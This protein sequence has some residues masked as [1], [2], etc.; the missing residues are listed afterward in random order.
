MTKPPKEVV[1][2]HVCIQAK[3]EKMCSIFTDLPP[4]IQ[5]ADLIFVLRFFV[6]LGI[7]DFFDPTTYG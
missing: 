1:I 3:N 5:D 7:E 4:I 6:G 2:K